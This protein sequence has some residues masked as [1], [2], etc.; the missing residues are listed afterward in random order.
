MA[1]SDGEGSPAPPAASSSGL[2]RAY[3]ALFK[4]A[5]A[6]LLAPA[7]AAI[8]VSRGAREE[9]MR[10]ERARGASARPLAARACSSTAAARRNSSYPSLRAELYKKILLTWAP[11]HGPLAACG[12]CHLIPSP[13]PA[14]PH[15]RTHT[16]TDAPCPQLRVK[17]MWESGELEQLYNRFL[18][19]ELSISKVSGNRSK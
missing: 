10:A 13:S 5:G 6:L 9:A 7:G 16:Q 8:A 14:H 15:T 17:E 12:Y 4:H 3:T 2:K 19:A 11:C 18:A 1:R